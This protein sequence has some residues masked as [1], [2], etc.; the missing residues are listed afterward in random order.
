VVRPEKDGRR[1]PSRWLWS[2]RPRRDRMWRTLGHPHDVRGRSG[3]RSLHPAIEL[4]AHGRYG[5]YGWRGQLVARTCAHLLRTSGQPTSKLRPQKR[6]SSSPS[7]VE[8][9]GLEPLTP[10]MP[11]FR[12]PRPTL[13]A[14]R[15]YLG[16]HQP[17]LCSRGSRHDRAGELA[18]RAL[19]SVIVGLE[20]VAHAGLREKVTRP[21]RV[22]FEFAA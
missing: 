6:R 1:H 9:R 14:Y 8:L 18:L 3:I 4:S 12:K 5:R 2:T 10:C 21:R 11:S 13:A 19:T 16:K 17:R 22:L 20:S 7:L 15:Y